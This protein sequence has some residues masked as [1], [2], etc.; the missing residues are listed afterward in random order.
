M[1]PMCATKV[2]FLEEK[3]QSG[4]QIDTAKPEVCN[5]VFAV[6]W[7]N[8]CAR[9]WYRGQ[10]QVLGTGEKCMCLVRGTSEC[11]W[12]KARLTLFVSHIDLHSHV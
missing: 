6:R 4:A 3:K 11:V 8:M 1:L 10:V 5:T 2:M 7:S 9:V 12:Y